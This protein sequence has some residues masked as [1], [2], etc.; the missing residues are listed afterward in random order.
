MNEYLLAPIQPAAK[1]E[2]IYPVIEIPKPHEAIATCVSVNLFVV[3][4]M[5]FPINVIHKT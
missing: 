2:V 1:D 5:L 3:V 4:I